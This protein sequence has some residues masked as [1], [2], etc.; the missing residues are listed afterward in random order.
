MDR[1]SVP[2]LAALLSL[3]LLTACAGNGV[4]ENASAAASVRGDAGMVVPADAI[5]PAPVQDAGASV[6]ANDGMAADA[7]VAG[8]PTATGT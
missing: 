1:F 6:A 7:A 5:P 4:R 3:A 8:T 2:A